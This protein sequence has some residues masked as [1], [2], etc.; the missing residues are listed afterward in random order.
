MVHTSRMARELQSHFG[1]AQSRILMV[2]HGFDHII[3][4]DPLARAAWRQRNG[5]D[6]DA[7]VVLFFGQIAPY[8]G[9]DLLLQAFASIGADQTR[10]LVIAGKCI[11]SHIQK[12]LESA[13]RIHRH[14]A[15]IHWL[16]EFV[17]HSE[18]PSLIHAADC[19]AMPYRYIDQSGVLLLALSSGLPVVATDV[20][21]I[22][23][24]M[25]PGMGEVVPVGDVKAFASAL[26]RVISRRGGLWRNDL[27]ATRLEW[28]RTVKPLVSA[29]RQLWPESC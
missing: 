1:V 19:L 2:E 20:G 16:D 14:A 18:V 25:S 10:H 24:Y 17:P 26:D 21:S 15:R 27:I 28:C 6:E 22:R 8:K 23:E 3:P 29:Y 7:G 13:I 5:I 11:D 9:L 4:H 12:E